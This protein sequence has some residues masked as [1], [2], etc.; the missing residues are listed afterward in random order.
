M[1]D[2]DEILV[3]DSGNSLAGGCHWREPS[4]RLGSNF[5]EAIVASDDQAPTMH[6][7]HV[8]TNAEGVSEQARMP[9]K[10]FEP[11]S[12]DPDEES[13]WNDKMEKSEAASPSRSFRSA[14]SAT[15]TR[16]RS[17]S[18]SRSFWSAS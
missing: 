14:G 18:G 3:I 12:I 16:T 8:Y 9:L 15:G 6:Y 5:K 7:R 10:D 2:H 17:R 4:E 11:K 1:S 13:Q